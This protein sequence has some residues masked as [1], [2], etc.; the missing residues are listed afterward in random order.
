MLCLLSMTGI[1]ERKKKE[2]RKEMDM[3]I[4]CQRKS[5]NLKRMNI[6]NVLK[7]LTCNWAMTVLVWMKNSVN[8]TKQ[9]ITEQTNII[10]TFQSTCTIFIKR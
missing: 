8:Y 9:T 3:S 6:V 4:I 10:I 5:V 2:R 1:V 7:H